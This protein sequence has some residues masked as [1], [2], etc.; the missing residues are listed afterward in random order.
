MLKSQ[1]KWVMGGGGG[2]GG[3]GGY[4]GS[5]CRYIKY[6]N[7][8]PTSYHFLCSF[9]VSKASPVINIFKVFLALI[10]LQLL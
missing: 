9:V 4:G 7:Y 5:F 10:L 6:K 1:A 8:I 2:R 3:R